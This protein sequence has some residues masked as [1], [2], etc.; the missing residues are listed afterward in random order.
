MRAHRSTASLPQLHRPHHNHLLGPGY[1]HHT[2]LRLE[3]SH[4]HNSGCM[5]Q[6]K[7]QPFLLHKSNRVQEC[8]HSCS[9]RHQYYFRHRNRKTIRQMFQ[10]RRS[11]STNLFH[12][13]NQAS[14]TDS[15][16]QFDKLRYSR[17]LQSDS[18]H[19]SCVPGRP[20]ARSLQRRTLDVRARVQ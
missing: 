11:P 16:S 18:H 20:D 5:C 2:L 10:L 15:H 7:L 14:Y 19:R 12:D 6:P 13:T 8:I 3:S 17:L 9:H 1:Y 4:L